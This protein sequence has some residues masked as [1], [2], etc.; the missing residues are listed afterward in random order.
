[1][2]RMVELCGRGCISVGVVELAVEKERRGE[3]ERRE[4]VE[5][6]EKK[7]RQKCREC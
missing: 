2:K 4:K 3:M 5:G 7:K 1:M 6:K